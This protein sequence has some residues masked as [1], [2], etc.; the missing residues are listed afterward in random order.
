KRSS[1][2][3]GIRAVREGSGADQRS[4][5]FAGKDAPDV[6][7][8]VQVEDDDG[9]VVL[10]AKRDGGRVHH[11]ESA[12]EEVEI[13]DLVEHLGVFDQDRIG[14]VNAVN[15]GRLH[16]DVGLDLHGAE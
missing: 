10:A 5:F 14:V 15:L 11:L 7:R 9:Q 13:A 8:T 12:L 4:H 6:S 2:A 16:D 3:Q 1:A